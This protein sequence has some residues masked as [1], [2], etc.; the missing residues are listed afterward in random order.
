VYE[1]VRVIE[2]KIEGWWRERKKDT[3]RGESGI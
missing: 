3:V 1:S 2:R